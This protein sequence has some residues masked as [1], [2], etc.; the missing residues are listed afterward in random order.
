MDTPNDA[1]DTH[2]V[3]VKPPLVA[4]KVIFFALFFCLSFSRRCEGWNAFSSYG[5]AVA[6]IQEFTGKKRAATTYKDKEE[7]ARVAPVTLTID[8]DGRL[9]LL[10]FLHTIVYSQI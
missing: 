7:T 10:V 4:V 5:D 1:S 3:L 9:T 8:M 2:T 6:S